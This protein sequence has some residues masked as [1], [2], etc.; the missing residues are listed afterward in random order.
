MFL[1]FFIVKCRRENLKTQ[2]TLT[3]RTFQCKHS[4]VYFFVLLLGYF[5]TVNFFMRLFLSCDETV[6]D[7]KL[8]LALKAYSSL[9]KQT[10]KTF[11]KQLTFILFFGCYFII[12]KKKK[13]LHVSVRFFE[14]A[15]V[16]KVKRYDYQPDFQI[17]T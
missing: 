10:Q 13:K 9:K 16:L 7:P 8:F 15:E 12:A 17:Q 14:K 5:Y 2:C 3:R 11:L 6:L 1:Q 4:T